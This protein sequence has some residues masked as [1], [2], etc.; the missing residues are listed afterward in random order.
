MNLFPLGQLVITQAALR[1]LEQCGI[2]PL[3]LIGRHVTS[4][5]GDLCRDDI[6]A[7]LHAI[8][9]GLRLLSKYPIG[10]HGDAVYVIT[11]ADRSSTCI[12]LADEY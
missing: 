8:K 1:L 9:T 12:L 2:P 10:S 3:D 4:D 6:D 5:F 7:N 11:E